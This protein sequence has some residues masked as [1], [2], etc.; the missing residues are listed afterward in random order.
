MEKQQENARAVAQ[1]MSTEPKIRQVYYV[2]LESHPDYAVSKKQTS[3]FGAM[4]SFEVCSEDIAKRI[5]KQVKLIRFAE[6]L[7]GVETLITYPSL[8]THA[9]LSEKEREVIGINSRLLR[10]SVGLESVTDIIAD[11]Q[12]A[13][14]EEIKYAV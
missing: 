14:K 4:I 1:W 3:G 5:L 11:L 6:S 2:G 12:Q 7:G 8:Q 13:L 9:D 10:L